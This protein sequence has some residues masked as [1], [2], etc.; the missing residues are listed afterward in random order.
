MDIKFVPTFWLLVCFVLFFLA[1]LGLHCS[2]WALC[3]GVQASL[4]VARG[5]SCPAACGILVPDQGSNP[6]PLHWKADS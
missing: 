1:A 5:L 6:H 3:Y 2:V 4:A